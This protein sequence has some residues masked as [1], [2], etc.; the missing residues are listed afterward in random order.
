MKNIIQSMYTIVK[1]FISEFKGTIKF[2]Y[3]DFILHLIWR[4]I[5]FAQDESFKNAYQ[6]LARCEPEIIAILYTMP[7]LI[8]FLYSVFKWPERGN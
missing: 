6:I 2:S 7:R 1:K 3:S 4:N 5:K 8:K